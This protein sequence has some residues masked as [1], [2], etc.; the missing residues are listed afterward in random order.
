MDTNCLPRIRLVMLAL[1]WWPTAYGVAPEAPFFEDGFEGIASVCGDGVTNGNEVCDDFN[2]LACGTCRANCTVAVT[3]EHPAGTIVVVAASSLDGGTFSVSD[4]IHPYVTFEF[5]T[6]ALTKEGNFVISLSSIDSASLV[7]TKTITAINA[8]A[9]S[10]LEMTAI[11]VATT[12]V[13]LVNHSYFTI[14]NVPL[15]ETVSDPGFFVSGM[16]G[17]QAGDCPTSTSC[18]FNSDC[19]SNICQDHLCN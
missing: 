11:D 19:A 10:E 15:Q 2:T 16:S 6:N 5:D 13:G 3:P 8:R 12:I 9:D 1:L 7:K 18:N 4:G 14:G 17:G